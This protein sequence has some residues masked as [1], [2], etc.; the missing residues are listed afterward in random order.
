MLKA[1]ETKGSLDQ[2][3]GAVDSAQA[4]NELGLQ[5][6]LDACFC[7]Q[8]SHGRLALLSKIRT[9]NISHRLENVERQQ[10]ETF[11]QPHITHDSATLRSMS[12]SFTILIELGQRLLELFTSFSTT[13]IDNLKQLLK[14]NMEIYE[15]LLKLQQYLTKLPGGISS[16]L[17]DNVHFEDALGRKMSLQYDL[18]RH[19]EVFSS[20]LQC[21][22]RD[23]PGESNI[24]R[25]EYL[26]MPS[27]F[28]GTVIGKAD[29][30]KMVFPGSKLEMSI[31]L[32]KLRAPLGLCPRLKCSGQVEFADGDLPVVW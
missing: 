25:G 14:T 22:F 31:F 21:K 4:R 24:L 5:T 10:K 1:E 7:L 23:M 2:I 28:P 8:T 3:K 26:I 27:H 16:S 19:W 30:S 17:E 6:V 18:V 32:S 29:W 15:L 11:K 20:M 12:L 13:G 9:R